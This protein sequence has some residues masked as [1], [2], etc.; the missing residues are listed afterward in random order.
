M[1]LTPSFGSN[2]IL[3]LDGHPAGGLRSAQPACLRVDMVARQAGPEV[4]VRRG[5]QVTLGEMAAEQLLTEAGPLTD[6]AA[7]VLGGDLSAHDGALLVTDM[8][9]ALRR[10]I[11]FREARLTALTW[12]P[13]DARGGKLPLTLGLR[14]LATAVDDVAGDGATAKTISK[15]RKPLLAANFRVGGLPFDEATVAS[16]DLPGLQMVWSAERGGLQRPASQTA[17]RQFGPLALTIAAARAAQARAWVRKQVADGRIDEA[18]GLTLQVELLDATM[19]KVLASFTLGGCLLLG[20][21]ESALGNDERAGEL[22]LRF[23]V[24]SVKFAFT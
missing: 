10:R 1:A 13:L 19:K 14:W 23:D 8:N 17:R 6:W 24:G 4:L 20:M 5:T 9:H 11:G 12:S 15:A 18:E 21:D 2:V 22:V 7:A 3:E 16:V